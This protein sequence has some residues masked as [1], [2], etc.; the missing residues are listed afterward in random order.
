[1]QLPCKKRLRPLP[2]GPSTPFLKSCARF[3][4]F[5]SV[6]AILSRPSFKSC[7]DSEVK[8]G[9]TK[10]R[11]CSGGMRFLSILGFRR[12]A[13]VQFL[14]LGTLDFHSCLRERLQIYDDGLQSFR[15][16]CLVKQCICIQRSCVTFFLNGKQ[17]VC[18]T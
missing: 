2:V 12:C 15:P 18:F 8:R 4:L 5:P 11:E 6:T 13:I 14:A 17:L 9:P 7:V 16:Y 10:L 1:M 3:N